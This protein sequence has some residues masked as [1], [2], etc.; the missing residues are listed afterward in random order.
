MSE[1]FLSEGD[2]SVC[3]SQNVITGKLPGTLIPAKFRLML[4]SRA[5]ASIIQSLLLYYFLLSFLLLRDLLCPFLCICIVLS[6]HSP[7]L[8]SLALC[9]QAQITGRQSPPWPFTSKPKI[10]RQVKQT[11]TGMTKKL[12][13]Y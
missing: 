10:D 9:M 12:G 6:N 7:D 13:S 4:P 5:T 11:E 1:K 2:A 3:Y 8:L